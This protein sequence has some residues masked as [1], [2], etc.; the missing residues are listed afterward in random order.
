M[1]DGLSPRLGQ[2]AHAAGGNG[3]MRPGNCAPNITAIAGESG[4]AVRVLAYQSPKPTG[5]RT[6]RYVAAYSILAI[7]HIFSIVGIIVFLQDPP[8]NETSPFQPWTLM[9]LVSAFLAIVLLPAAYLVLWLCRRRW[10]QLSSD[11]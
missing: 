8:Y 9:L 10:F 3:G 7:I 1:D 4:T 5:F 11:T 2:M 6:G